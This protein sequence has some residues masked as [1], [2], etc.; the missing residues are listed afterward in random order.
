MSGEAVKEDWIRTRWRPLMA[1]LYMVTCAF[2][3]ILFPITWSILQATTGQIVTQWSPI[4]LQGAGLYH[5]AM[6]A[7]LGVVA[8][9]RGQE[10]MAGVFEV[11]HEKDDSANLPRRNK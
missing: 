1:W 10:K 7:V 9:S 8:W 11:I 2:D 6:G 4:T 3:F 5:L